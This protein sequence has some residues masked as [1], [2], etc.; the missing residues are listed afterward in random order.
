MNDYLT[1]VLNYAFEHGIGVECSNGFCSDTPCASNPDARRIVIN[2]NF[3]DQAQL[4][5]QAA[6]EVGHI[7]NQH[8]GFMYMFTLLKQGQEAEANRTAFHILVPMYFADTEAEDANSQAFMDAFHV[9]EPLV[10]MAEAEIRG[11]YEMTEGNN[12]AQS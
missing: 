2:L 11:Y 1:Q 8:S 9:P 7:L 3:H 5:L 10:G 12:A 6:H 4:P